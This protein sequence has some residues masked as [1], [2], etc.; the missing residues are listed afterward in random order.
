MGPTIDLIP[1]I[2]V[3]RRVSTWITPN[4]C[5]WMILSLQKAVVDDDGVDVELVLEIEV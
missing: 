1:L 3:C 5:L 4:G 2:L